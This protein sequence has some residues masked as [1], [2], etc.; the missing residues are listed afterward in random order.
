MLLNYK[1]LLNK[2]HLV[3]LPSVRETSSKIPEGC[4][5]RLK[6]KRHGYLQIPPRSIQHDI[7]FKK[8]E[9]I[10]GLQEINAFH[11]HCK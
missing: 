10:Q 8:T 5:I 2:I 9:E 1:G 11:M 7:G 3:T 6:M 4:N